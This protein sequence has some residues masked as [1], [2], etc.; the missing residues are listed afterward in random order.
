MK[1]LNENLTKAIDCLNFAEDDLRESLNKASTVE[2]III[3][4]L[5]KSVSTA[6]NDTLNLFNAI[7][8]YK[9]S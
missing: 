9:L 3:L 2:T 5:I 4:Q 8:K 7:N 1:T 6:R